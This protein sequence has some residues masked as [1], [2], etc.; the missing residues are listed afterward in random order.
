MSSLTRC[1]V[2]LGKIGFA[3]P[4]VVTVT[5]LP[6]GVSEPRELTLAKPNEYRLRALSDLLPL[7][8][9]LLPRA[10]RTARRICLLSLVRSRKSWP[11]SW[12]SGGE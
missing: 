3:P 4:V 12:F 2:A 8:T 11:H 9:P 6:L 10:D 1:K 5:S 7:E